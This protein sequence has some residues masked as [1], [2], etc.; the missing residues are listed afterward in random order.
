MKRSGIEYF[1]NRRTGKALHDYKMISDGDRILVGVSGQDSLSLLNILNE[2]SRYVPVR[3][4]LI[5]VH[6]D[7]NRKN[8]KTIENYLKKSG[9]KYHIIKIN[10]NENKKKDIHKTECFWCSWK[11]REAIFKMANRVK[12]NKIVLAH[13]LDDIL[14]TL[15]MNIFFQG[16][17][18]TM[19]PKLRMFKGRFHIIRPFCY[20]EK[21][22]IEKYA[23]LKKIPIMPYECPYGKLTNRAAMRSI[24]EGL[25]KKY[26][27]VKENIFKS[28]ANIRKGY[29][30]IK[31]I[32]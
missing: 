15:F 13:H 28:M 21:R 25:R 3:Y 19:P 7:I 5:P 2:R 29:L 14:E 23:I 24:I 1:L 6:I 22:Q 4:K 12:C 32:G 20:L 8:A 9:L 31:G 17:T 16:E 11:R 10:L 30:P 27:R 26:P 18:S